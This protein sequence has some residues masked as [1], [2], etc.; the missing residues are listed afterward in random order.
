MLSIASVVLR[1]TE[2]TALA[3]VAVTHTFQWLLEDVAC[4][5]ATDA[6]VF[7]LVLIS[8]LAFEALSIFYISAAA[9]GMFQERLRT[10]TLPQRLAPILATIAILQYC[11]Y[12]AFPDK[13]APTPTPAPPDIHDSSPHYDSNIA[14]RHWLGIAPTLTQL[15]VLLATTAVAT[16]AKHTML[17]YEATDPSTR[18]PHNRPVDIHIRPLQRHALYHEIHAASMSEDRLT[19]PLAP[20]ATFPVRHTPQG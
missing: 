16:S 3:L 13:D 2:H 11:F 17:W 10:H 4:I 9:I 18:P 15:M 19:V 5:C 20:P 6:L 8:L 14:L 7:L 1:I 12:I